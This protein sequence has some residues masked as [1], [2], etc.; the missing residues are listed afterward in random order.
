MDTISQVDIVEMVER[1]NR[2]VEDLARRSRSLA[3]AQFDTSIDYD[4]QQNQVDNAAPFSDLDKETSALVKKALGLQIQDV[5]N[6]TPE[7][8]RRKNRV[9]DRTMF[10]AWRAWAVYCAHLAATSLLFGSKFNPRS[11]DVINEIVQSMTKEGM[12]RVS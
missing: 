3:K 6:N 2:R 5:V 1:F 10:T 11:D 4:S 12:Y 7:S 8:R 9:F